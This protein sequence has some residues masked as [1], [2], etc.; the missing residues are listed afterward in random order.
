MGESMDADIFVMHGSW[1]PEGRFLIWAESVRRSAAPNGKEAPGRHPFHVDAKSLGS[2]L[3]RMAKDAAARCEPME[4]HG[5]LP[6]TA[7]CPLPSL[8]CMAESGGEFSNPDHWRYWSIDAISVVDPQMVLEAFGHLAADPSIQAG[9]DLEFWSQLS[10]SLDE[11]I[12]RH[13]YLPAIFPILDQANAKPPGRQKRKSAKSGNDIRFDAGW[14]LTDAALEG[15]VESFSDGMPGICRSLHLNPPSGT[16]PQPSF[17]AADDLV[18]HFV[19]SELNRR[20]ASVSLPQTLLKRFKDP[21]P[22]LALPKAQT[23]FASSSAS[24]SRFDMPAARITETD[25]RQWRRWR[26]RINRT[27]ETADDQVSFRLKDPTEDEPDR[28]R[29]EWLLTSR[30]D[31]SLQ[32]PMS[33][34]WGSGPPPH[35]AAEALLQ[36]GQA[37]RLYSRLWDGMDSD[38]PH[39][40]VLDRTEALE[41]LRHD[42]PVLQGAGFRV[43]VPSWWTATGQRR[44]RIRMQ[45][46]AASAQNEKGAGTESSG[47]LGMDSIIAWEPS[48]VLDGVELT[49]EEWERIIRAK[50]GLVFARGQW[51]ELNAEDISRLE[52]YWQAAHSEE[53]TSLEDIL[54]IS[55]DPDREIVFDGELAEAMDRFRDPGKLSLLPQ[56]ESVNGSLRNY[57]LRGFSWLSHAEGMEIGACLADDMGLGKTIQVLATLLRAKADN[58]DEGPTMLVAPTSVLGNWQSEARRFAP[59]LDVLIHHGGDRAKNPADMKAAIAGVDLV[60]MSF[61]IARLDG[62]WL[63]KIDWRRLVIDE[64]QNVKNPSAA[65]TKALAAIPAG[66]RIALTGTP[67]ENRLL[68]LWSLFNVI[69]PGFLGNVTSFRREFERPIMR[70]GDRKTLTRLRNMVQ[71]FIL[72]RL[73]SDKSIISDLPEKIEQ[74][75]QCSLTAEQASLYEAVLR[76]IDD[77]LTSAEGIERRGVMLSALTRLK[78]ICNHPAQY[79]QDGSDFAES[80]SHKLARVCEMLEEIN[81][82]GESVLVFSQF[83]EVGKSLESLF[84]SRIGCTV[85]YLHGGTPMAMR[86]HMVERF[87]DSDSEPAIFVLSLRAAGVGL[88]LTRASHVIHFDRWWN[89]AVENQA[90]DRAYRIGQTKMVMVHKMVTIGTLEER[91]DRL[92]ESKRQLA[93]DILGTGENWLSD[94]GNDEFRELIKLDRG[95]IN[96]L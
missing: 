15:I 13:E 67:V 80:R 31:P 51:M 43:I 25:W 44:L 71:P 82:A 2:L 6:G 32:V 18:R 22:A 60:I 94:M 39:E 26:D 3:A 63:K 46:R 84:R 4:V 20:V 90:T 91:I 54:K 19:S 10:S 36:L 73:K 78:Q 28:W 59:S 47:I 17:Y 24:R 14:E 29:L 96:T 37:A 61:G 50:E 23:H 89:P 95:D 83:T 64:A 92:I 93:E 58:P 45:A 62:S 77:R 7:K 75:A 88:T 81:A 5:L 49:A 34:F 35:C 41:F 65:I 40:I 30:R 33:E 79:L 70:E 87:Q 21:F 74:N 69:N 11:A 8:Q 72:R 27:S 38:R 66:R 86:Q 1:V 52:D 68:D 57:Q 48:V 12:R 55:A 53:L 9:S 85:H 42:A 16:Q 56:P 76:D